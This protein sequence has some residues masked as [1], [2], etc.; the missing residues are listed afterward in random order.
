MAKTKRLSLRE[1]SE[2]RGHSY[3]AGSGVVVEDRLIETE[4]RNARERW[5]GLHTSESHRGESG[6]D[7]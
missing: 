7:R 5:Q 3:K 6:E 2:R 4:E 1:Q